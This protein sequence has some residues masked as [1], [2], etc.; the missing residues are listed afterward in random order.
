MIEQG[1]LAICTQRIH[2]VYGQF[3][4]IGNAFQRRISACINILEGACQQ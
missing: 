2:V 3:G 1:D 4:S